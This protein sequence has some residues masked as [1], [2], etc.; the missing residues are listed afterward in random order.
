[1]KSGR[2]KISVLMPVYNGDKHLKKSINSILRQTF[3]DFEL[4]IINDGS[5]DQSLSIIESYRDKRIRI[6]NNSKNIGIADSLNR[7]I[8]ISNGNYIARQ[9][10]DDISLPER[11]MCQVNYLK[12]NDIDLVDANFAFIDEDDNYIQDY[13]ERIF[14]PHE[15]LSFLFFYELVH[16]AIMCKRSLFMDNNIQYKN[17]PT[18]DYDLFIRLAKVGMTV[19]RISKHLLKVRKYPN[20]VSGRNWDTMKKDINQMRI[21]LVQDLGL[22]PTDEEKKIHIALV[23]Q[24]SAKLCKY[25]F[26]DILWWSNKITKANEI[27]KIYSSTYFKR[28]LYLRL[29]RV[30]KGMQK[31]SILDMLKLKNSAEL[32]DANISLRD[33][34]YIYRTTSNYF[35]QDK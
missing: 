35:I 26:K 10:A 14:N 12:E 22:Q 11:F 33:L 23:E 9:D 2:P 17:R 7:G 1:M 20:S 13:E 16:G 32:Y 27:N 8:N 6:L 18:E 25:K 31:K 30:I 24:N 21:G 3:D 15:T 5:T 4:I 19:G 34:F 28:Q 29:I